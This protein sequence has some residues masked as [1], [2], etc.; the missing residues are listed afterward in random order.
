MAQIKAI[1]TRYKGY[2]FRS[3]LEARWAVFLD[4]LGV[5]WEYEVEGFEFPNGLRYLPDFWLPDSGVFLEIKPGTL[6]ADAKWEAEQKAETLAV[7]NETTTFLVSGPP[8]EALIDWFAHDNRG[9]H[10]PFG[11]QFVGFDVDEATGLLTVWSA[12]HEPHH[13]NTID[14]WGREL[15][16]TRYSGGFFASTYLVCHPNH[17]ALAKRRLHELVGI[18]GPDQLPLSAR[19]RDAIAAARSARFE[20]GESGAS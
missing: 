16:F 1:Q 2:H 15:H 3:R 19:A 8:G 13:D 11:E 17:E 9:S 7:Y 6:S 18:D 4:A 12:E 5:R 20:F 14:P 10:L